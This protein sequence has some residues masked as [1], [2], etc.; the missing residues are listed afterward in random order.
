MT[1]DRQPG[2]PHSLVQLGWR[3]CYAQQLTLEDLDA[4]FPARVSGVHRNR[5]DVLHEGG[6]SSVTL[7]PLL[8]VEGEARVTVGDWVLVEAQAPRVMRLLD[9]ASLIARVAAGSDCR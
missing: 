9:R 1:S 4:A 3:A 6:E 8:L 2:P 5:I 7:P